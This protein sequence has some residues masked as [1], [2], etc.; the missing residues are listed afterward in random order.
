MTIGCEMKIERTIGKR[1]ERS[2]PRGKPWQLCLENKTT[3]GKEMKGAEGKRTVKTC[4]RGSILYPF[5]LSPHDTGAYTMN[6]KL[7]QEINTPS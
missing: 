5:L 3:E 6:F 4:R 7:S 2:E 1:R